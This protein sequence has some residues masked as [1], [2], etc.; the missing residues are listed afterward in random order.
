MRELK[1]FGVA[2]DVLRH[3]LSLTCVGGRAL[4]AVGDAMRALGQC[5]AARG[6]VRAKAEAALN[7]GE[8]GGVQT[9]AK[10]LSRAG[11]RAG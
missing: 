2:I 8:E 6:A 5:E 4:C 1:C 3:V 11:N 10:A 7:R 9:R